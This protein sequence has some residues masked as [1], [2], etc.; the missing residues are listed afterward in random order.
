MTE[1]K[2]SRFTRQ[3]TEKVL[4]QIPMPAQQHKKMQPVPPALMKELEAVSTG[5][6]F[7]N[8]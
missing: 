4:A 5:E 2:K 6:F 8:N 7:Q 3:G 1:Q